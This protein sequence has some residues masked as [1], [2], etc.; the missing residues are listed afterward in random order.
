MHYA[1]IF[2][3]NWYDA[4]KLP[5]FFE[6]IVTRTITN[7]DLPVNLHVPALEVID[8]YLPIA[9]RALHKKLH[10]NDNEYE[11]SDDYVMRKM[12]EIELAQCKKLNKIELWNAFPDKVQYTLLQYERFFIKYLNKKLGNEQDIETVL[13]E[14]T[15]QQELKPTDNPYFCCITESTRA[16]GFAQQVENELRSACISAP[17]LIKCINNL[18]TQGHLDTKNL[19]NTS[20]Y[21]KLN[22]HFH[23]KYGLRNFSKYRS[24]PQKNKKK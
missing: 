24:D 3:S 1:G 7:N 20:L 5:T 9:L 10:F 23:L 17:K 11:E 19:G 2:V 6:D 18:E 22:E 12:L 21:N 16:K 13:Q 8:N 4:N 14:V 15:E